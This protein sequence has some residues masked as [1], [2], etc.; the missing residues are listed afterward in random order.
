MVL[1]GPTYFV[2][3]D[4]LCRD[5]LYDLRELLSRYRMEEV[6]ALPDGK[7]YRV[8]GEG[9]PGL[10]GVYRLWS[11][12]SEKHFY[13]IDRLERN[14]LVQSGLWLCEGTAFLDFAE[15]CRAG[16]LHVYRF[17]AADAD[18]HFCTISE[19]EKNGPFDEPSDTWT[20]EGVAF[21]TYP[22]GAQEG[23]IPVHRFRSE[24]RGHCF[25]TANESEKDR[26]IKDY[27]HVWTY[28]R[29]VW[30]AYGPP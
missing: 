1:S 18:T 10:S 11:P 25:Y 2:W 6:A 17:R 8:L 12:N 27:P 9:G 19:A 30:Y 7:V 15:E 14:R 3:S 13:T 26:L 21:Y 23:V 4:S 22:E 29:I 28:E 5:Y 20:C 24:S 16:L